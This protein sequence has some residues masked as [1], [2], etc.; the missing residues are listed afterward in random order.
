MF[1]PGHIASSRPSRDNVFKAKQKPCFFLKGWASNTSGT[2]GNCQD[3]EAN[4]RLCSKFQA[5]LNYRLGC[6]LKT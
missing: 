6:Y 3:I 2:P 1:G 4:V 5:N